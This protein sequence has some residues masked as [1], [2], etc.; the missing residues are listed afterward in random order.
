MYTRVCKRTCALRTNAHARML[1]CYCTQSSTC[2]R[3]YH[4]SLRAHTRMHTHTLV[5]ACSMHARV[6]MYACHDSTHARVRAAMPCL[7][8]GCNSLLF[9]VTTCSRCTVAE[10]P[11]TS[12][13]LG[14]RPKRRRHRLHLFRLVRRCARRHPGARGD[15]W[16]AGRQAAA[17]HRATEQ[18]AEARTEQ[19][20]ND[21]VRRRIDVDEQLAD[22]VQVEDHVAAR[23]PAHVAHEVEDGQRRLADDRNHHDCAEHE[24]H[25]LRLT[26]LPLDA[27]APS[28]GRQRAQHAGG[29]DHEREERQDDK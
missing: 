6:C 28:R 29:E 9:T 22:V 12:S 23:V 11:S 26:Q 8:V 20:V 17:G 16:R 19:A 24:R 7:S 25:F 1:R 5:Y 3:E 27:H 18:D 13:L 4:T 15:P 10:S 21:E 14:G 2:I